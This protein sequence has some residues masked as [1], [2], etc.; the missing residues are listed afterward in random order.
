MSSS[1]SSLRIDYKELHLTGKKVVHSQDNLSSQLANLSLHDEIKMTS[2]EENVVDELTLLIEEIADVIDESPIQGLTLAEVDSSISRLEGFRENLRRQGRKSKLQNDH[3]VMESHKETM[4]VIKD[5]IKSA[6]DYKSKLNL[7]YSTEMKQAAIGNERSIAFIIEDVQQNLNEIEALLTQ[8]LKIVDDNKLAEIKDNH[9]KLSERMEKISVKYE[10]IL[11]HPITDGEALHSIKKIG[12][13]YVKLNSM[14]MNFNKAVHLEYQ[15]RELDKNQDVKHIKIK[16]DKFCGYES[17]LDFYTFKTNFEKLHLKTT[18]T[19]YL[20]DLLKNNYLGEPALTLVRSL[21]NIDDIWSRLKKAFGDT[22]TM[23]AKKLQT[24]CKSELTRSRDPEKLVYALSKFTNI[25][26]EI[27]QLA[28]QHKIEENLY[29]GDSLPRI[30]QQLGD[31]R[32]TRFLS[33]IADEELSEKKTWQRLLTFL[34]KEEK[35]NQHKFVIQHGQRNDKKDHPPG[36]SNSKPN[37]SRKTYLG[38]QFNNQLCQLC[39]K[40]PSS[41]EHILSS[42]PAGTKI[43]QYHTCKTF[44]EKTPA[45]RL[46][47]LTDKGFCVQCL[48]PGADASC[49]KHSDGRCQHEY[50]CP[51]PSHQKYVVRKHVLLCEEHKENQENQDVLEKFKSRCMRSSQLPE[52]AKQIKLSFHASYKSDVPSSP[53]DSIVN[54]GIYLLQTITVNGNRLNVFYDNG[55]S[56]FI[57]STKAVQLLGQ[58]AF[59][60][61]SEPINLGGVGKS[62]TMSTGSYNVTLPLHNGKKITLSGICLDQITTNF[63]IYPLSEVERDIISDYQSTGR[64]NTLPKLPPSVGGEIHLML[65]VKYLRYHPR[66]IHQLQ[67]GLSL[68]ESSFLNSDGGR[69]VVGGPHKIFT[70]IHNSFYSSLESSAY[71]I[72]ENQVDDLDLLGYVDVPSSEYEHTHTSYQQRQFEQVESTGCEVTYRCPTCRTCKECKHFEEYQSVSIREEVEQNI[73]NSSVTI[74]VED[75]TTSA[76]LPFIADPRRLANNKDKAMK[77]YKQQLRKLNNPSNSKDKDDIIQ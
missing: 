11:H 31:G 8:D 39:G 73:I 71:F 49:G 24:L 37:S 65:G 56:D 27:M 33:S 19:Y 75:S 52:F 15:K 20:P 10:K 64:T 42:G 6:K 14:K 34:E 66:L 17:S 76:S 51:H 30:Y 60:Y 61:S 54:K 21:D 26:R 29:F 55:C 28:A 35:L 32:L 69:G 4:A 3:P 59:K 16:M 41:T 53:K 57:L 12:E 22:K 74:N 7:A 68:Y 48:L 18:P 23:L 45:S 1:R 50:I 58:S 67:S 43:I 36:Q 40:S 38:N 72:Q 46:S 70:E 47:M 13:L 63:P 9:Q 25:I 2:D 77:V 5:Y 44:A 62:I